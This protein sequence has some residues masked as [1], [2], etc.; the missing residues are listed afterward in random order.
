MRCK[1]LDNT[2]ASESMQFKSNSTQTSDVQWSGNQCELEADPICTR[3]NSAP[4]GHSCRLIQSN[5]IQ[6]NTLT[7]CLH[8]CIWAQNQNYNGASEIRGDTSIYIKQ[9]SRLLRLLH[10]VFPRAGRC[11]TPEENG[12]NLYVFWTQ[13]QCNR[14]S[15]YIELSYIFSFHFFH[16][17]FY[18]CPYLVY[19]HFPPSFSLP[20]PPPPVS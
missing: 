19:T 13:L 15:G 8:P 6:L 20:P 16:F 3:P 17:N 14:E 2:T 18:L 10:T 4:N 9:G 7:P 5:S 1:C 11:K 12:S